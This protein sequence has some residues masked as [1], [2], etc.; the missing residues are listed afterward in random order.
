MLPI[1]HDLRFVST[2][3]FLPRFPRESNGCVKDLLN[4]NNTFPMHVCQS[5][6][7]LQI[8]L[9][10]WITM[11]SPDWGKMT[12]SQ[13]ANMSHHLK[14]SHATKHSTWQ[15]SSFESLPKKNAP[16]QLSHHGMPPTDLQNPPRNRSGPWV[17]S[18]SARNHLPSP[19]SVQRPSNWSFDAS[20]WAKCQTKTGSVSSTKLPNAIQLWPILKKKDP[21][22]KIRMAIPGIDLQG[23]ARKWSLMIS[24]KTAFLN[25]HQPAYPARERGSPESRC[26]HW[27]MLV[28]FFMFFSPIRRYLALQ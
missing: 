26:C 27:D 8:S 19:W 7:H 22:K 23:K 9:W 3:S 20:P 1:C 21:E 6:E 13:E 28:K 17:G 12:V 15:F 11:H 18:P 14:T 4:W 16:F 2:C 25:L 10:S 5:L 24:D